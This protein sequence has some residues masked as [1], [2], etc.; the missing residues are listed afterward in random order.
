MPINVLVNVGCAA[1]VIIAAALSAPP[2]VSA[3]QTVL[4]PPFARRVEGG[5]ASIAEIVAVLVCL[6]QGEE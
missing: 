4:P 2:P 3:R 5:T 6:G 1:L